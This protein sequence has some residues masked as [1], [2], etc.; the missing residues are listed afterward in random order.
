[1]LFCILLCQSWRGQIIWMKKQA[2]LDITE[3]IVIRAE[4]FLI[5]LERAINYDFLLDDPDDGEITKE[6]NIKGFYFFRTNDDDL[7]ALFKRIK[8]E[9]N[10]LKYKSERISTICEEYFSRKHKSVLWKSFIEY[11]AIY[12][13]LDDSSPYRS[14]E[15]LFNRYSKRIKGKSEK[16]AYLD[17][18]Y[19]KIFNEKGFYD[20]LAIIGK[21]NTKEIKVS[22]FLVKFEG[23]VEQLRSLFPSHMVKSDANLGLKFL[24][25]NTTND[26]DHQSIKELNKM[27]GE[28]GSEIRET[29]TK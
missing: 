12:R 24:F 10:T 26:W 14:I 21:T 6:L 9:N 15:E 4:V 13:M 29:I 18:E 22:E 16:Y 23:R 27:I 20:V 1:M 25:A 8:L 11:K 28:K 19:Q 3:T 17:E 7:N 5:P 2:S